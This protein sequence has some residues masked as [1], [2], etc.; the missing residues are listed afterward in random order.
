MA[1]CKN[2]RVIST[3]GFGADATELHHP[4]RVEIPLTF[5][6]CVRVISTVPG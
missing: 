1:H 6:Q 5:L 4:N 3:K 2:V